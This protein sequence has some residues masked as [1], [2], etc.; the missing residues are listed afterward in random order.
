[1]GFG[2][3][4]L[5][6]EHNGS[7]ELILI[8]GGLVAGAILKKIAEN[9]GSD[10]YK[11]IS[12]ILFKDKTVHDAPQILKEAGTDLIL[13]DGQAAKAGPID[14]FDLIMRNTTKIEGI[15]RDNPNMILKIRAINENGRY[16]DTG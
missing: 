11:F 3:R 1:M 9:L 8:A 10:V 12:R 16:S 13:P 2:D 14:V 6:L 7:W 4:F 15:I 5:V